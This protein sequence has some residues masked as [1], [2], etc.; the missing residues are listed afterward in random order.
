MTAGGDTCPVCD[1]PNVNPRFP[2]CA[3]CWGPVPAHLKT[4]FYAARRAHE[5]AIYDGSK[6]AAYEQAKA[7]AVTAAITAAPQDPHPPEEKS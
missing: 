4:E 6:L 5:T 2:T 3:K 1:G 7:E